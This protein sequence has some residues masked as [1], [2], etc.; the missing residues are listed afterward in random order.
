M[1]KNP[2]APNFLDEKDGRF[3]HL[4]GVRDTATRELREKGV[5]GSVQ[6]H[7]EFSV[8]DEELLWK[9]GILGIDCPDTLLNAVFFA[10]GKVLCL[11]GGRE[12]WGL[13]PLSPIDA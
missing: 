3:S 1:E 12:H 10:N 8:D 11:H 5:G 4:R 7:E 6:H 13:N 2:D 9:K